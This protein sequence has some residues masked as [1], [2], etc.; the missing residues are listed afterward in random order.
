MNND[1]CELIGRV[2]AFLDD[3]P[4]GADRL[5]EFMRKDKF[6][7]TTADMVELTGWSSSYLSRLCSQGKMPHITGKPTKFVRED[8][9][10]T[11]RKMQT[12]GD[13]GRRK[14]K[15]LKGSLGKK[16]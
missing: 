14:G 2:A 15:A 8:V 1:F 5:R 3:H 13:Y 9:I 6:L 16:A 7:L 10:A 12:G 11:L 4:D